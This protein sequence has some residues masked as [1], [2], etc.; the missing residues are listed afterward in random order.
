MWLPHLIT[1]ALAAAAL[2]SGC[3][4]EQDGSRGS[5]ATRPAGATATTW[6]TAP[7]PTTTA[8]S[9]PAS[10]LKATLDHYAIE[11]D[12]FNA[13]AGTVTLEVA[14]TD[15][16]VHDIVLLRTDRPADALPSVGIRLA[17][18]DPAVEVLARTP[19]LDPGQRG[20]L[21]AKLRPGR[22]VL[23]CSVPHH[24]VREAMAATL[25]VTT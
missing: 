13:A 2:A 11:P 7:L 20:E 3:S 8:T 1:A 12:E 6:T 25:T 16:V 21:G 23:V 9:A 19:R 15:R 4:S 17:E 22:Y 10:T 5:A 14:N 24:Y 18:N